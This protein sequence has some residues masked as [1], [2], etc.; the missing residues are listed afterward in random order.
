MAVLLMT[1]SMPTPADVF[2]VRVWGPVDPATVDAL[3]ETLLHPAGPAAVELDLREV[4]E[5]PQRAVAV[6]VSARRAL[7]ERLRIRGNPRVLALVEDAG[8]DRVLPLLP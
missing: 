6:L 8:L 2:R 7:G 5:F 4:T 3:R 1:P